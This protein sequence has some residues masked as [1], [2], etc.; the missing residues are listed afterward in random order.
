MNAWSHWDGP[1][2]YMWV[3]ICKNHKFHKQH[4]LFSGHKIPLGETDALETPP[5][6][7]ERLR[8][9]CDACGEENDYVPSDLMRIQ[10][11]MHASFKHHPLFP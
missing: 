4:N 1:E 9:R 11:E 10:M 2:G 7:G 8:V 3:V 5:A 6:F